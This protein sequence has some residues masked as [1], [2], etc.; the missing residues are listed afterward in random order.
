MLSKIA[1]PAHAAMQITAS[2]LLSKV[3]YDDASKDKNAQARGS[4]AFT[5]NCACQN[6][7][8]LRNEFFTCT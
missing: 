3:S 8:F 5:G 2:E 4:R 1:F 7:C 6:F